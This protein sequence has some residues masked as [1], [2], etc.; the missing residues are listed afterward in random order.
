MCVKYKD[1]TKQKLNLV[2]QQINETADSTVITIC[3][4]HQL[5]L[6]ELNTRLYCCSSSKYLLN[7]KTGERQY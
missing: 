2:L 1:K 4:V 3:T 7:Y 5:K 6:L